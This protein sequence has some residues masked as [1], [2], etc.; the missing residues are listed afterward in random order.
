V[1][2]LAGVMIL[3]AACGFSFTTANFAS[4]ELAK[5]PEGSQ[6]TTT[7][8]PDDT[9][10]AVIELD[11]APEDTQVRAEWTAVDVAGEEP[12]TPIDSAQLSTGSGQLHFSLENNTPWPEGE[13][14]VDLFI[15]DELERTLEFEVK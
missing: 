13:Y 5:D 11:N 9:F 8:A 6:P 3:V 12:N 1:F 15:E 2:V 7:F 4:A 10:Y 14:K